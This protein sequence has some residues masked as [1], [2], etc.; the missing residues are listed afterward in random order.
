MDIQTHK[1]KHISISS[2]ILTYSTMHTMYNVIVRILAH[3]MKKCTFGKRVYFTCLHKELAILTL[4]NCVL[5]H[6]LNWWFWIVR[7]GSYIW[8][9]SWT[10][11]MHLISTISMNLNLPS[12]WKGY[13]PNIRTQVKFKIVMKI[14]MV[15]PNVHLSSSP[16][17]SLFFP[18][19]R[20]HLNCK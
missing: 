4:S 14:T 10:K 6:R 7:K 5:S 20:V 9:W 15:H 12:R 19:T 13:V 3:F 17:K 18:K 11:L 2:W 16:L 1:Q 8:L